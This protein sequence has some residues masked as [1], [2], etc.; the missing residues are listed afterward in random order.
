[1]LKINAVYVDNCTPVP[2][3]QQS[4]AFAEDFGAPS[5]RSFDCKA[6]RNG[7]GKNC[8]FI[9]ATSAESIVAVQQGRVRWAR[10]ES[11]AN[12]IDTQFIDLPL[13]DT[14]GTLENEMKGKAGKALLQNY[15]FI[16]L[17]KIHI[18]SYILL[19]LTKVDAH[20]LNSKLFNL[21]KADYGTIVD[22]IYSWYN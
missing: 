14:E 5:L 13:A 3:L 10:E 1:M 8:L 15:I 19:M 21:F 2:E 22:K 6:K 17:S 9:F 11:L 4:V 20:S 7:D 12:V 18:H 16:K